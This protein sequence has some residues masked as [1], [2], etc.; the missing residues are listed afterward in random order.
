MT[1]FERIS[2]PP[3]DIWIQQFAPADRWAIE[4]LLTH[5]RL[6]TF[7]HMVSL[8]Q[9]AYRKLQITYEHDLE[10][11]L[12]VP[13]GYVASS[14]AAVSYVFRRANRLPEELFVGL[15]DVAKAVEPGQYVVFL[16]DFAGSGHSAVRLWEDV[17]V[18]LEREHSCKPIFVCAVCY[19]QALE[20]I[21]AK[22][23][24]RTLCPEVISRTEQPFVDSSAIFPTPD[25]RERA[26]QIVERYSAPL[27]PTASLGYAGVQALVSFFF[28]TPDDTLPI[29]WS[30]EGGWRPLFPFGT[31]STAYTEALSNGRGPIFPTW[32][33]SQLASEIKQQQ[34]DTHRYVQ[35]LQRL[36]TALKTLPTG[37]AHSNDYE[38]L[39]GEVIRSCFYAS[40]AN[41][42]AKARPIDGRVVRDW[43]A[44][45]RAKDGFWRMIRETY[46]AT[47]VF[48]ECKNF[49]DLDASAFHQVAYYMTKEIGR[50]GVICFRGQV[51]K[52]YF[53][54]VKRVAH[55]TDGGIIL[56]M[57]DEDLQA[58]LRDAEGIES[59]EDHLMNLYDRTVR[60]IS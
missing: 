57:G 8:L 54:H 43:V 11:A 32:T 3:D 30:T 37:W 35:R 42:E 24:F 60:A 28:N 58:F 53:Q 26:R 56:L 55:Q 10:G 46:R 31:T 19:E 25:E 4:R 38:Q 13:G 29:F 20:Y 39:V 7:D 52:Q 12:F 17:A 9:L 16:D 50:F 27:S 48:W 21:S 1:T 36:Q 22:T 33:R 40:L 41:V 6:Y 49:Q 15:P 45:N 2:L 18:R 44:A 5:F 47:Q 51:K 34:H 59:K 23:S 14:A